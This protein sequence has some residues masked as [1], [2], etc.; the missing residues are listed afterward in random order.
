M[1]FD[2]ETLFQILDG[3]GLHTLAEHLRT[4]CHSRFKVDSHGN[5]PAWIDAWRQ[6]PSAEGT[7][8]DASGRAIAVGGRTDIDRQFLVK[9]LKSFHPWRKGPFQLFTLDIDTEWRSDLKWDR[10][11][12]EVDFR[13]KLVLDV[14]CGNGYYGWRMLHAGADLVIGCDPFPL[15][16]MQ[17]EVLRRY[18]PRPERH[19][20]VPLADTDLLTSPSP[21]EVTLSMGVLYHQQNPQQ[22][23]ERLR[24]TL[25]PG[26]QLLLETLIIDSPA[27]TSLEPATRYAKMKNVGAIP[28]LS[29]LQTWLEQSGFEDIQVIDVSRTTVT[30][31]RRTAWMTFESLA[32]FLDPAD[33]SRTI[34]VY[35]APIRAVLSARRARVHHR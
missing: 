5:M 22:H 26:G 35:P 28:S 18:A 25:L 34:E 19:F 12:G 6:L 2:R 24:D 23:L 29:L 30:E 7:T 8:W 4:L 3:R 20:L 10:I 1:L 17:F 13:H 11:A 15:Y 31:Q 14:G 32:D 33:R 16:W 27:P 21:F 9:Q